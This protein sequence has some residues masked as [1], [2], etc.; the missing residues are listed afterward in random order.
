VFKN[1]GLFPVTPWQFAHF[2]PSIFAAAASR[3]GSGFG[4]GIMPFKEG[5]SKRFTSTP[6]QEIRKKLKRIKLSLI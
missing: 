5:C 6:P 2:G 1:L 3:A 4:L